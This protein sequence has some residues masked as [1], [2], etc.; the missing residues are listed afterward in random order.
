MVDTNTFASALGLRRGDIFV[1]FDGIR[2][3]NVDQFKDVRMRTADPNVTYVVWNTKQG[4][5]E[6]K[7]VLPARL[8]GV[9]T[10]N[11]QAK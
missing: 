6:I 9:E 3:H 4:Y 11:W 2:V 8:L 5:R 10:D 7:T 1:G